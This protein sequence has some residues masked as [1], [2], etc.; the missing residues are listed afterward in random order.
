M[1]RDEGVEGVSG[2]WRKRR[3]CVS[4]DELGGALWA[5]IGSS[6]AWAAAGVVALRNVRP[7]SLALT[8]GCCFGSR[9]RQ[10]ARDARRRMAGLQEERS[11]AEVQQPITR[12]GMACRGVGRGRSGWLR[13]GDL[14][15]V[16][17]GASVPR[18][19]VRAQA[20]FADA[21]GGARG[22][23][24][25]VDLCLVVP[26]RLLRWCRAGESVMLE[27]VEREDGVSL[28][29]HA[30]APF[31]RP[32]SSCEDVWCVWRID[33]DG[34]RRGRRRVCRERA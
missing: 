33:G 8:S 21:R 23:S 19:S 28:F 6:L 9:Q 16:A 11:G 12:V 27:A 2:G 4:L 24:S 30:V 5:G 18:R 25:A 1:D 31:R 13:T 32:R 10:G 22:E 3:P 26:V 29:C 15:H 7:E 14:A 34:G 17:S 20:G